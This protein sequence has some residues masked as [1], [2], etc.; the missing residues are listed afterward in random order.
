MEELEDKFLVIVML[1]MFFFNKEGEIV[2][3]LLF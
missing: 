3:N 1:V 2:E